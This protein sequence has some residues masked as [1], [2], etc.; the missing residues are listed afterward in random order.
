MDTNKIMIS[1]LDD[2]VF[3]NRNKK[4]GAYLLRKL[5]S[6]HLKKAS[7]AAVFLFALAI[8][9]PL[10]AKWAKGDNESNTP[11]VIQLDLEKPPAIDR[12]KPI[13]IPPPPPK[14]EAPPSRA[15]RKYM[16]PKVEADRNVTEEEPPP[17]ADELQNVQVSNATTEGTKSSTILVAEE[18]DGPSLEVKQ[19]SAIYLSV[20][21]RPEFPD[22]EAA[23]LRYLSQH[24]KYPTLARE[25]NIEGTVVI[26][27]VIDENGNVTSPMVVK[28]IGGGC[29]EEAL[30]VIKTMPRWKPGRQQ[31]RD[32]KVRFTLPI[33]FNL[34]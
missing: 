18:G 30:R 21:Q 27:F 24:I 29:N 4:Y 10:I 2:I 5:Y 22:G 20:E 8:S 23:L 7:A 13:T 19:E 31:G 6:S 28:G 15:S 16:P 25:I 26:Q 1:G 33:R 34:Q 14:Y 3:D 17:R 12:D 32:V 9:S 11:R